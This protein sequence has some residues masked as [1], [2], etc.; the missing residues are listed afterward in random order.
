MTTEPSLGRRE[1]IALLS[2]VMAMAALGIDMMLPAFDD[3]RTTFGMASD[4][5]EVARTVTTYFI[6][7]AVAPVFYGIFSDRFGRKPVLYVGGVIYI[8]G[9]IGSALAPT[10]GL[11]LVARFVWGIGAAGGRILTTAVVRDTQRGDQMARTMSYIM[12]VFILV[13][14]LAPALGAI[15]ASLGS[16]RLVF[17]TAALLTAALLVWSLRLGET[18]DPDNRQPIRWA[19]LKTAIVRLLSQRATLIPLLALMCLMG[20]MSSY[21][22]SS[23]LL[24]GELFDR[25]DQFP[26]VFGAVAVVLG[27]AAFLNGRLVGRVGI[28]SI[29][30]PSAITYL[31]AGLA[32]VA[33]SVSADGSPQFWVFMPA[34][35]V[36]MAMQMLL[37]PNLNTLAMEPVGDIAGIAAAILGSMS[38]AGGAFMG[39]IVDQQMGPSV[40]PLAIAVAGAG[41]VVTILVHL[42]PPAA[43]EQPP[44]EPA[45][46]GQLRE[47]R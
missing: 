16:W 34:L 41:V 8:L 46:S 4:S 7:I 22:A 3:I 44:P 20:V 45:Q 10:F 32:T 12:T 24:V 5:N 25:G 36:A 47:A 13:P 17:W 42:L 35:T 43:S 19:G 40:T 26:V 18:L 38:T 2:M 15:V 31:V 21:L 23:Q 39:A 27:A 6:G 30:G 33:I 28:R 14:V 9:A 1:L 37:V 11:L 29:L